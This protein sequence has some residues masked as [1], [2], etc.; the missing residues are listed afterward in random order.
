MQEYFP[1]NTPI[2]AWFYENRV[3]SL[4]GLGRQYVL[5][6]HGIA[7]DGQ[8]HT[9][10]IQALIDTAAENGGGVIVVP[11]GT[12][13]TGSL[14]FRQ[15]VNLY[16]AENGVLQGSDDVSDYEVRM[17]RI[18][19]ENCM[20]LTALVN[21]EGLDGFTVCGRGTIDGNGL[22]AWKAFQL[23][24]K[25]NPHCTNKDEQRPRLL[26][27]ADSKNVTVAGLALIN[28][29]F[30][31]NHIYRCERVKFLN[32][33]ICSP[34]APVKAPSTDAIDIDVCRD[35]L[36]K[37]CY[38]EVNDDAVVLKGGKG[39][40]ASDA[41]ENG[42]N[43]R[44]L[45]EDCEYGFCHGCLTCGSESVHNR[46]VLV[47][48]IKVRSG[49]NLLWLK[50]RPDT[51]QLYEYI[52][53]ED[54]EGQITNLLNINPWTQFYDLKD[55]TDPPLSYAEHITVRRCR[56]DCHRFFCVRKDETQYR[57]SD[58]TFADLRIR[59]KVNGFEEDMI[60]N[61]YFDDVA[62]EERPL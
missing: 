5:S 19:G 7:D 38:M 30:W 15:G 43:E 25:W 8:V 4:E 54:V 39:P 61:V 56:F 23:R 33:R 11:A 57:L 6:E 50:M 1:D 46:N 59:A 31:T 21:A 9:G 48:R 40:W 37:G 32:C 20:Y 24:R 10:Q 28:S 41:P 51:P 14:F 22:R 26:Y 18:E 3:P 42:A 53:I 2:D 52:T 35:V 44:I 12:Y 45:V 13:R 58:F 55:R 49:F 60:D 17:T 47:R 62:V 29:H 27:I 36:I 34:S 16:V